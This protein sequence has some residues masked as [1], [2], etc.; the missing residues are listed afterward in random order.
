MTGRR[1]HPVETGDRVAQAE[2]AIRAAG[3][4]MTPAK[5]SVLAALD[6]TEDDL[7]AEQICERV[8]SADTAT[9]YRALHQLEMAGVID[10][11]HLAH[12]P[13]VYRWT[14]E[15]TVAIVC[16]RCGRLVELESD[17]FAEL[18]AR[19][20]AHGMVL[21]RGHFALSGRCLRCS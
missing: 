15:P 14:G 10:H 18:A 19:A 16:D 6:G 20:R 11:R 5:R 17:D 9:V 21:S 8:P 3:G 4:R 13:A 7:T 1:P 2:I 12:G